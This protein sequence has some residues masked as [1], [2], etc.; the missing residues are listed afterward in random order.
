MVLNPGSSSVD[1]TSGRWQHK[2]TGGT[3]KIERGSHSDSYSYCIRFRFDSRKSG[4]CKRLT[5][6]GLFVTSAEDII[7]GVIRGDL[8]SWPSSDDINVD[9]LIEAAFRHNVHLILFDTL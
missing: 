5:D 7:C 8:T 4:F 6:K 2:V 3:C 1:T 9:R